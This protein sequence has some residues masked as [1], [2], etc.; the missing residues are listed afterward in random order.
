M[1]LMALMSREMMVLSSSSG[2]LTAP[3]TLVPEPKCDS[4]LYV[5]IHY[6]YNAKY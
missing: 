4:E 3:D 6:A 2:Q 5:K 1:E